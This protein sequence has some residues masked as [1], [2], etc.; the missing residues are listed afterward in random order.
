[1]VLHA[2]PLLLL[3]TPTY[4]GPH[5]IILGDITQSTGNENS[6]FYPWHSEGHLQQI[7]YDLPFAGCELKTGLVRH[8]WNV[9]LKI[10]YLETYIVGAVARSCHQYS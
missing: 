3:Q 7:M 10:L 8:I 5:E 1:M 4:Q 6:H 2:L 9:R